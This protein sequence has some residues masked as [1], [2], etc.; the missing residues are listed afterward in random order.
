MRE[1]TNRVIRECQVRAPVLHGAKTGLK[2]K[3]QKEERVGAVEGDIAG[4]YSVCLF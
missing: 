1:G 3:Y 4:T 2:R